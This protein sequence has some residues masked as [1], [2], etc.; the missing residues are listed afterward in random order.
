MI[1]GMSEHLAANPAARKYTPGSTSPNSKDDSSES[2]TSFG[3]IFKQLFCVAAQRLAITIH[4]PLEN[5]GV[6]FEE[7]LETGALHLSGVAKATISSPKFSMGSKSSDV[8][9]DGASTLNFGRGKYLFLNR[10]LSKTEVDKFAAMGY[11]FGSVPQVSERLATAM[12]VP[13]DIMKSR[14]DRMRLVSSVEHHPLPGVHMA[15]FMLRPSVHNSFDV[16]VPLKTQNQLPLT[17]IQSDDLND[18]QSALLTRFDEWTVKDILKTLINEAGCLDMERDFRWRLHTSLIRLLDL[19]GDFDSMMSA[20]FSAKQIHTPCRMI[21]ETHS[22]HT[23][24]LLT[25]RLMNAVHARSQKDDMTYIPLS[26]FS[27][28]QQAESSQPNHEAFARGVEME[29][30]YRPRPITDRAVRNS[31]RS[32]K[33]ASIDFLHHRFHDS[34]PPTPTSLSRFKNVLR[35]SS[36]RKSEENAIVRVRDLSVGTSDGKRASETEDIGAYDG[37]PTP[38]GTPVHDRFGPAER[39]GDHVQR[40]SGYRH[41]GHGDDKGIELTAISTDEGGEWVAELFGL[42]GLKAGHRS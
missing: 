37:A 24:T 31:M 23:C 20:K 26:F 10:M 33:R 18:W 40:L 21:T 2:S 14:L 11:R 6:L 29:F 32:S 1:P 35:P 27:A 15:C 42:F 22:P 17:T 7:P 8:E 30:G 41:Q 4:E 13:A 28:Q 34:D 25:L 16:L 9:R 39:D 12:E 36:Q 5:V 38:T 19:V 3:P